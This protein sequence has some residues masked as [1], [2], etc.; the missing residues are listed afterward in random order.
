MEQNYSDAYHT[1]GLREGASPEEIRSAYE[2]LEA[3]FSESA[4]LGSPLWE[5][6]AEKRERFRAAYALLTGAQ[7][8]AGPAEASGEDGREAPVAAAEAPA[9]VGNPQNRAEDFSVR[10]RVRELLNENDPEAAA[11]LLAAQPNADTDPELVFL[12]GM[13]AWQRGWLD[14][15]RQYTEKAVRLA[16][17]NSEYRT[18]LD[19][20]RTGPSTAAGSR[21]KKEAG[22][23]A[24]SACGWCTCECCADAICESICESIC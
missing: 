10:C 2:R 4:Y 7:D 22:D 19:K 23:A 3:R 6:A 11:A 20:V 17:D 15:A 1:L 16:P 9:S 12:R 5:A 8:A 14:E 18:W 24:C 21:L 13:I